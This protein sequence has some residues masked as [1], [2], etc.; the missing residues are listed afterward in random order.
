MEDAKLEKGYIV[1]FT[2]KHPWGGSIGYIDDSVDS[3]KY[4][5]AVPTP[6]RG[7]VYIF[8]KRSEV[9]DVLIP[10]NVRYPFEV[11]DDE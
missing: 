2:E 1:V 11:V 7:T 10:M 5:I 4:L 6:E 3:S 9:Y 8:V